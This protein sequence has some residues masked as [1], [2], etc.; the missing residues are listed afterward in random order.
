MVEQTEQHED[1][2]AADAIGT[3][4]SPCFQLFA[5][6]K[7]QL[8]DALQFCSHP[9][10]GVYGDDFT[11]WFPLVSLS[12]PEKQFDLPQAVLDELSSIPETDI[13]LFVHPSAKRQPCQKFTCDKDDEANF[14]LHPWIFKDDEFNEEL[15]KIES[16]R[17]GVFN[18]VGIA[19]VHQDLQDAGIPF[20][21]L[22]ERTVAVHN[23]SFSPCNMHLQIL[24][25]QF[26]VCIFTTVTIYQNR[27]CVVY[28]IVPTKQ[29]IEDKALE[30]VNSSKSI[31]ELI[32]NFN[33]GND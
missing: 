8:F 1:I 18:S 13:Y 2:I 21:S 9:Y 16:V 17:I 26:D 11:P 10:L 33:K 32:A 25:D 12:V 31:E 4:G 22:D 5:G 15:A 14:M 3:W 6:V 24:Y 27:A 23:Q 29:D 19:P 7:P 20:N 30:I 28:S